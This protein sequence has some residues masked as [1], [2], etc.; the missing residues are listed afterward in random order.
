MRLGTSMRRAFAVLGME[1]PP[2]QAP[3][4][5]QVAGGPQP[6]FACTAVQLQ[7]VEAEL[8]QTYRQQSVAV[9]PDKCGHPLASKVVLSTSPRPCPMQAVWP[10]TS[11]SNFSKRAAARM[12]SELPKCCLP[13]VQ[14]FAMLSEATQ[15][16][17]PLVATAAPLQTAGVVAP[18]TPHGSSAGG[19]TPAANPRRDML[20]VWEPFAVRDAPKNELTVHMAPLI[21]KS[22]AAATMEAHK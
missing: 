10:V 12:V 4:D 16:V 15:V 2:L 8:R 6:A 9:H 18:A 3:N 7:A 21:V 17:Q 14:A 20:Q 11:G 19:N 5:A 13:C 22:R 1:R